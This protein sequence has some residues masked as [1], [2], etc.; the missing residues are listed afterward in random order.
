MPKCVRVQLRKV[1]ARETAGNW[2]YAVKGDG[3]KDATRTDKPV[4]PVDDRLKDYL[5]A[6][7][8]AT[9]ER[10]W[11][12][13]LYRACGK[14]KRCKGGP[15]GTFSRDGEPLCTRPNY[16]PPPWLQPSDGLD[17]FNPERIPA[18]IGKSELR[19]REC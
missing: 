16:D 13:C 5:L 14:H 19:K 1:P 9:T 17:P 4:N 8:T 11:K 3:M 6:R 7:I 18:E 12:T 15:R 10:K 2:R